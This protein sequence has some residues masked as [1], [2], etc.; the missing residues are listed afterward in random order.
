MVF[1]QYSRREEH[2]IP[3]RYVINLKV[4]RVM[5]D[6]SREKGKQKYIRNRKRDISFLSLESSVKNI[7]CRSEVRYG[8]CRTPQAFVCPDVKVPSKE[9]TGSEACKFFAPKK[10]ISPKGISSLINFFLSLRLC[11]TKGTLRS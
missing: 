11:T 9:L 5:F 4:W 7:V 3:L 1:F 10:S 2:R 8:T 6:V